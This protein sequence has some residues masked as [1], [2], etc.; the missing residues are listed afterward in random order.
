MLGVYHYVPPPRN[1]L[2]GRIYRRDLPHDAVLTCDGTEFE[3]PAEST[4]IH[5]T[6]T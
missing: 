5:A 4:V 1:F 3:L 2:T 6:G